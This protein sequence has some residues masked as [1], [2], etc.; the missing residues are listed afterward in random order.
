MSTEKELSRIEHLVTQFTPTYID[1]ESLVQDIWL[2]SNQKTNRPPSRTFVLHRCLNAIRNEHR[3][4]EVTRNFKPRT[5]EIKEDHLV[6][7][8]L[9]KRAGLTIIEKQIIYY[10]F[11]EGKSI[12]ETAEQLSIS[13]AK[14]RQ[15]LNSAI[16]RLQRVGKEKE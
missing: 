14:T 13:S 7:E 5:R 1:R 10:H 2:E 15:S 9:I 3:R 6:L 8:D 4:R 11:Y 16:K 12:Y